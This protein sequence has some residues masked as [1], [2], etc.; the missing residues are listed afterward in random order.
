MKRAWLLIF[1]LLIICSGCS[2]ESKPEKVADIDYHVVANNEISK[3]LM[4]LIDSKKEKEFRLTYADGK[5]LYLVIGYGKKDTSGYS[6]RVDDFYQAKDSLYIQ[7]Q[8]LGPKEGEEVSS[9][10]SYPWIVV[11]IA[12]TDMTVV[13]A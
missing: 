11:K 5:D 13:F 9:E 7:T 6:I 8:L 3:E 10:A 12:Y 1:S 4:E 2:K